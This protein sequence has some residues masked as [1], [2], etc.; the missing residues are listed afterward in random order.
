MTERII[1][2]RKATDSDLP[3]IL[4]SSGLGLML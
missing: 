1:K 2:Y 3:C 4:L